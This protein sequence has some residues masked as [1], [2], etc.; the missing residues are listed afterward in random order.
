MVATQLNGKSLPPVEARF[1]VD[2]GGPGGR[3]KVGLRLHSSMVEPVLFLCR[4]LKPSSD[5]KVLS[6]VPGLDENVD[7]LIDLRTTARVASF[8]TL[9]GKAV[10]DLS[11]QL[12]PIAG[13]G[14]EA[15]VS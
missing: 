11:R 9:L 7:M 10:D 4:A 8:L 15:N 13:C 14:P 1:P 2:G 3:A 6:I 5:A 12:A